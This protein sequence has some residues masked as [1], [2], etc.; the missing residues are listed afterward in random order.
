MD[1]DYA[2]LEKSTRLSSYLMSPSGSKVN[3]DVINERLATRE[4]FMKNAYDYPVVTAEMGRMY[5]TII[6][7]TT[8]EEKYIRTFHFLSVLRLQEVRDS[9]FSTTNFPSLKKMCQSIIFLLR[10]PQPYTEDRLFVVSYPILVEKI[11]DMY[12]VAF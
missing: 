2:L 11:M 7:S 8:W 9:V 1:G 4:L 5:E 6:N 12:T 10:K 3:V